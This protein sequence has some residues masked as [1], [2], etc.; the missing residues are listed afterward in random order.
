MLWLVLKLL[1]RFTVRNQLVSERGYVGI[2]SIE[3]VF[4][5][6]FLP[7]LSKHAQESQL[8]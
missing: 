6:F 5:Y 3:Y 2:V 7:G 8:I 4:T 1:G